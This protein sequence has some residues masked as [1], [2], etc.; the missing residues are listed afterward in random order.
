MAHEN[1]GFIT[2]FAFMRVK[3]IR[4]TIILGLISL[5]GIVSI[6]IYWLFTTWHMQQEKLDE[7]IQLAL[8]EV[9]KEINFLHDCMP[10]EVNPVQQLSE[11]CYLV[12][13]SC[14]FN[15]QNLEYLVRS[16]FN[17]RNVGIEHEIAIYDCEENSLNYIGRF[18]P[19]GDKIATLGDLQFCS[20]FMDEAPVYYFY[21]NLSGRNVY[22]FKKM[23]LWLLLSLLVLIIVA[24]FA[25]TIFSFFRQKQLAELQKD[26]INN[27]THEFK[28]PI[29]SIGIASDVLLSFTD[30]EIPERFKNYAKIIKNENARLNKQV[31]N[32]LKAARIEK[33]KTIMDVERVNLHHI[34]NN[35]FLENNFS[36]EDKKVSVK[37]NLEANDCNILADKLHLTNVLFNLTDNAIKYNNEEV[38]IFITTKNNRKTIE[39]FLRDNGFGIPKNYHKTV[40]KKFF[41]VPKGN[42]HD[43]KGFG[44]G[45]FYVKQ[46]CESHNWRISL[47][48]DIN[49]GTT[50]KLIIPIV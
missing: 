2:N 35:V 47:E 19:T 26:F 8:K 5:I 21:I 31:E 22:L 24:F 9:T 13:V 45:L 41:R 50:F 14:D 49:R 32:V 23:Q 40:F 20:Y 10:N 43:V 46:V 28:T 37:L 48:S 17:K 15:Q 29:S 16:K 30:I 34:I 38:D 3:Q 44:L 18:S 7:N 1:I 36:K 27:M 33:G 12:D 39:F 42:V 11:T 4:F 6:Q 25:Y